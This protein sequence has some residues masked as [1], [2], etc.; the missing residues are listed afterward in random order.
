MIAPLAGAIVI[1]LLTGSPFVLVFAVLSP[2]IA[3]ATVLDGRRAARRERR[4]EEERFDREC[5]AY[6]A[7]IARAHAR[8]RAAA[9][10]RDPL[11]IATPRDA[12]RPLRV[13]TAPAPSAVAP[14]EVLLPGASG[15][16][17]RLR[18]LIA[19]AS[20][21][22]GLPVLVPRGTVAVQGTGIATEALARRLEVE[23]GV[24]VVRLAAEEHPAPDAVAVRVLSA[25]NVEI[26]LPD[27]ARV[28]AAPEFLSRRQLAI[29]S[30]PRAAGLATQPPT[31]VR[32]CDLPPSADGQLA[33][34]EST[35]VPIG[36]D[37][38][39][40]VALDLECEGPHALVG[41]TTGSGKSEFL[42]SL[43]LGWAASRPPSELTL[44]FVDFKGGATF[45]GLT[46]LP[47]T[48]GLVTD[49]DPIVAERA[50][51]S[52]RAELRRRERVLADAGL[53]DVAQQPGLLARLVV[54][55]DEF[56]ALIDAFPDLHAPFADLS[57]RGRS[58]G[59]HLVLC[60]QNPAG[61]VRDAVAANCAVRVAFRL[62]A[63]AG[64]GFIGAEGRELAGAPAGR[65]VL[66][67]AEGTRSL[68]I[69]TIDDDDIAAVRRRWAGSALAT[70]P[71]LP[72]LP[73]RVEVGQFDAGPPLTAVG[74]E[75]G[76]LPPLVFGL[77][78][79]PAEQRQRPAIWTPGRDGAVA[80][81]GAPRSGRSTALAALA[82]A[83]HRAGSETAVLPVSVTEA[84]ALLDRL[85]EQ[86]LGGGLLLADDL[87]LLMADAADLA[88]ELLARWDAAVRAQRRAG[89]GAAAA[90]GSASGARALLG[91]RFESRLI[92]RCLDADDHHLA[93]APRGL[94]DRG[95]IAGRGW[96]ADRQVQVVAAP[97][98]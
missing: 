51:L 92:L 35:G 46:E 41:G 4:D 33:P 64:A 71:W 37:A 27:G 89:G 54:L 53:R 2:L 12:H 87:D 50:L 76:E 20:R 1:G 43:A 15:D 3:I 63:S 42:R 29:A 56:A 25:T 97:A 79:D 49:L 31:S 57:A 62:S 52:L 91:A 47:H 66:V 84:W 26:T 98:I 48:V 30:A 60:T 14:D 11:V 69:A 45:A 67:T 39:G 83:A 16:E 77:L 6:E 7:A 81:V 17:D 44:L 82:Q 36:A 10:A 68:Q 65:A 18:S 72:P 32:W 94:F 40:P 78:D 19:R 90:I 24:S 80:V 88:P 9:D 75:P 86:P 23:P 13:G 96:W 59:V 28:I 8:E 74:T 95:A 70:G 38:A 22:A 34:A 21:H 61:A 85:A 55:V 58:L 93:G 5:R 73:D